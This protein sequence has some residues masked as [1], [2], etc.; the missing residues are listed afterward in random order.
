M[1]NTGYACTSVWRIYSPRRRI[2]LQARAHI[3]NPQI[4]PGAKQ[5]LDDI[6]TRLL[7]SYLGT[8]ASAPV[9]CNYRAPEFLDPK[10]T[11]SMNDFKDPLHFWEIRSL[12][13]KENPP[14]QARRKSSRMVF[15]PFRRQS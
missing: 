3:K 7:S 4:L 11:T 14:P 5:V 10:L 2:L 12:I 8:A 9:Q 1:K 15:S 6:K 13:I